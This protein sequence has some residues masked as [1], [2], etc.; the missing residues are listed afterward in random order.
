MRKTWAEKKEKKIQAAQ[1]HYQE[2]PHM[3]TRIQ[4]LEVCLK[5]W[6]CVEVESER[7]SSV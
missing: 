5:G 1:A 4:P 7:E 3:Y 6:V 2:Q